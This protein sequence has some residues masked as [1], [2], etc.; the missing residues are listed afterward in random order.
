MS[1]N[2]GPQAVR[3]VVAVGAGFFAIEM[4][5]WGGDASFHALDPQAFDAKTLDALLVMLAYGAVFDC[6]GGYI[7]GRLAIRQPLKH[8]LALGVL[9]L[10]LHAVFTAARWGSA[11]AWYEIWALL[12]IVPMCHL[13]G[14]IHEARSR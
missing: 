13:G 14:W 5:G 8:A 1:T 4:L 11:P 2:E 3:S 6:V 9:V 12:L 7:A 10:A